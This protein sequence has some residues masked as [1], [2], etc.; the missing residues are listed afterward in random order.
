[1]RIGVVICVLTRSVLDDYQGV[2]M[3]VVEFRDRV[4]ADY[5]EPE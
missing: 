1:M 5:R 4:I 3:N 2:G